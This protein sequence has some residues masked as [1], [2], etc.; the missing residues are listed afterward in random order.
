V[1]L[2]LAAR[3]VAPIPWLPLWLLFRLSLAILEI[4][5]PP[6]TP[7]NN[8]QDGLLNYVIFKPGV[9]IAPGFFNTKPRLQLPREET[10]KLK[11]GL[12][13]MFCSFKA[14]KNIQYQSF[15]C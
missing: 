15:D 5:P 8:L 2:C 9:T 14:R 10:F 3:L 12:T 6:P 13:K 7:C 1:E 4:L 11:A